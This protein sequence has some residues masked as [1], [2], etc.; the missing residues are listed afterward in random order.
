MLNVISEE[1][2]NSL[3]RPLELISIG[4]CWDIL[5]HSLLIDYE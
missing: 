3:I 4:A 1:E 5:L 2:E